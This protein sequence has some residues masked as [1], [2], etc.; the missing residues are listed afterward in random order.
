MFHFNRLVSILEISYSEQIMSFL[1]VDR[2]SKLN[3]YN[4]YLFILLPFL[5]IRPIGLFQSRN[6]ESSTYGRTP[7]TSDQLVARSLPTQDN[8]TQ[9][10]EDKHPCLKR[11]SNPR[12]SVRAIKAA[13]QTA[14]P[15][16]YKKKATFVLGIG[17]NKLSIPKL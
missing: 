17:G 16:V 4:I 2:Q 11:D 7:W 13:P 10:D 14:L 9:A 8:T 12:F 5:R 1:L 3:V 6:Y 15:H